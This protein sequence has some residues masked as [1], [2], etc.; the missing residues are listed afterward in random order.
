MR[1]KRPSNLILIDIRTAS[2]D[3][4]LLIAFTTSNFMVEE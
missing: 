2:K 3:H 4:A 1:H